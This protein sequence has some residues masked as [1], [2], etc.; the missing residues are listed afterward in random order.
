M[1]DENP[2]G[3]VSQIDEA[4]IITNGECRLRAPFVPTA[5]VA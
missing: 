5:E 3:Q 1:S 4:R 2:M